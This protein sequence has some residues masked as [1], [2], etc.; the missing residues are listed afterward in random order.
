MAGC[1]THM[2]IVSKILD[3][4][5]LKR[6]GVD[7]HISK[8]LREWSN[9]AL[10]GAVSPDLPY[11]G[12]GKD[13]ADKFHYEKT[14]QIVREGLDTLFGESF[15]DVHVQKQIAWLFGYAAHLVTDLYIHPVIEKKV[16]PYAENATKHRICEMNQD[17]W[18]LKKEMFDDVGRCEIFDN[19]IK[20][21]TETG[22]EGYFI[23]KAISEF[24]NL[25][26]EKVYSPR[27]SPSPKK[28]FSC[29]VTSMDKFA[30]NPDKHL[31]ITRTLLKN[32]H[33]GYPSNSD[34]EVDYVDNLHR[35]NGERVDFH[36]VFKEAVAKVKEYWAQMANAVSNKDV[37]CFTLTDGN[38]DTGRLLSDP[39]TSIFW[40]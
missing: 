27:R 25:L 8:M 24:W 6:I 14:S 34:I 31:I 39:E 29:F 19:T 30:E 9:Y 4:R 21:C 7:T 13:W 1:Y 38:L 36:T 28:W 23:D 22:A 32:F 20:T 18:I 33:C 37:S 5:V 26:I 35:P 10:L 17:V 3:R 40:G 12:L 2:T 11:L 16:G 15:E